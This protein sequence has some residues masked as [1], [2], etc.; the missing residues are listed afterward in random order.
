MTKNQS[1]QPEVNVKQLNSAPQAS[2]ERIQAIR[3]WHIDQAT[4]DTRPVAVFTIT[5][6]ADQQVITQSIGLE[7]A[8]ETLMLH[9]LEAAAQTLRDLA[10]DQPA[11]ALATPIRP[12]PHCYLMTPTTQAVRQLSRHYGH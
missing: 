9:S 10:Q 6:T 3:K 8:I 7:P 5:V 4:S 12:V 1:S 11:P 2:S